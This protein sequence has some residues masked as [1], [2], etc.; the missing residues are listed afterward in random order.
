MGG[1]AS[2]PTMA[3]T[4]VERGGVE[5]NFDVTK[6]SCFA[7]Y[8]TL[9][10][11][12]HKDTQGYTRCLEEDKPVLLEAQ[13]EVPYD[14]CINVKYQWLL[15]GSKIREGVNHSGVKHTGVTMPVLCVGN[16]DIG[17]DGAKYSCEI[18]ADIILDYD[19][20]N[21]YE[22]FDTKRVTAF[23]IT[24]TVKCC[25]DQ[26]THSLASLYSAQPEVPEDTWP[27]VST[28]KHTNLALIKQD[29]AKYSGKYADFTIR[30]DMDDILQ[31]KQKIEYAEVLQGVKSN[32]VL[33]IEGRPGSGKTTFVHKLTHDWA[34][35]PNGALRLVLLVSLR[36]LNYLNK[37]SLDLLDILNLF[38]DLK[39]SKELLEERQGKGI[40]FVFDG[41]DEYSPSDGKESIVYKIIKKEYLTK[42]SVIV[43]SRPAAI[44]ELRRRADKVIEV[45][46]FPNEQ[47]FE[48]FDNY[49]FAGYS[50]SEDLKAYLRVHPNIL[51]MCYLPIH[52]AMVAFLFDVTGKVP[53]TETE[54]YQHFTD[55]TIMRSLTKNPAVSVD[56]ID[57]HNLSGEEQKLFNQICKLAWEKT[58]ANKQVLHQD[59]VDSY[60]KSRKSGDISLGLIS[61]DRTTCLYGLK[62]MY[63]FL[64]LTFQEY[65]AAYHISNLC[66]EEQ[67]KLIQL[68]GD[69]KYMLM[70]WKFLCGLIKFDII[71]DDKFATLFQKTLTFKNSLFLV[72]SA[73]ETQDPRVSDLLL[74]L[75]Q[76]K[77]EF[78]EQHLT[79]P[80]FT[81]LGYV[82]AHALAPLSLSLRHCNISSEAVDVMLSERGGKKFPM[83]TLVYHFDEIDSDCLQELLDG[84]R[85]ISNLE[86]HSE[87]SSTLNANIFSDFCT[88]LTM[89]STKNVLLGPS[90]LETVLINGSK[91]RELALVSSIQSNDLL[92]CSFENCT[93]LTKLDISCNHL[94]KAA[95][96][97]A[98]GL[99]CC[100]KLEKLIVSSNS[101]G[102]T[103]ITVL[104]ESLRMCKLRVCS[105]EIVK[106]NDTTIASLIEGLAGC[107]NLQELQLLEELTQDTGSLL[108]TSSQ[109]WQKL[110]SLKLN[111]IDDTTYHF[112]SNMLPFL[113]NLK[114]LEVIGKQHIYSH[115]LKVHGICELLYSC[116]DLA[117]I[118][119]TRCKIE[120][121]D[122]HAL[123]GAL[124]H[125]K[126]ICKLDMSCNQIRDVGAI[127]IFTSAGHM[128]QLTVLNLSGNC[129]GSAG[130]E[131]IPTTLINC[132]TLCTL[133]LNG[134]YISEQGA[135]AI[136][137]CLQSWPNLQALHLCGL[138]RATSNIGKKGSIL[139]AENLY[140][141]TKLEILNLSYNSI[142]ECAMPKLVKSLSKCKGLTQLYL[143]YNRI[144][145]SSESIKELQ[146]WEHLNHLSI[147][148][149]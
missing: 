128:S 122:V 56:D 140:H 138:N 61:V 107:G 76:A 49:R 137:S 110:H 95:K 35:A 99:A 6:V 43:A 77:F 144:C 22:Q 120:D 40:C 39:V 57:V 125:C 141:C 147:K 31:D 93:E 14:T 80:D 8:D 127:N 44:A 13:V 5:V 117:E 51:H 48:Y 146:S 19:D 96:L 135:I 142:D 7:C 12:I 103:G 101:I 82:M 66:N 94:G 98:P 133:N 108:V 113:T 46:G 38:K 85:A 145:E 69:K 29:A 105:T 91:L 106:G 119:I 25:L 112:I 42:S 41:L 81:A 9:F 10:P 114:I 16:A 86:I 75:V 55:L 100:K 92:N 115:I 50:K 104:L 36:V 30:G 23:D 83:H 149:K 20:Y 102:S 78:K 28:T 124:G 17:M 62:N 90:N 71:N 84:T 4:I 129:I 58:I 72:Q 131:A 116:T 88:D 143:D 126:N 123:I 111:D 21:D 109:N 15:N 1:G 63:T 24:L 118:S 148:V 34:A 67:H 33:F 11:C 132:A 68:H 64:H 60:F 139:L 47:I 74:K 52:A 121:D 73:Y 3:L 53:R 37:P 130:A 27:P 32:F 87:S 79:T 89:L 70:V 59:E 2:P 134:N 65:L 54:I 26:Y 136:S 45:L 18:A 97:L